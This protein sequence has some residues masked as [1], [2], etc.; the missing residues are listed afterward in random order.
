MISGTKLSVPLPISNRNTSNQSSSFMEILFRDS[1]I[2]AM[3]NR[4]Y[5]S[6]FTDVQGLFADDNTWIEKLD[7]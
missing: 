5:G 1:I 2:N 6:H 4:K 3:I 7:I